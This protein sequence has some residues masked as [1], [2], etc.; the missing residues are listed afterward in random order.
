[1]DASFA[2]AD[3]LSLRTQFHRECD[4]L[5]Q[6]DH[7]MAWDAIW[8]SAQRAAAA[9]L[10]NDPTEEGRFATMRSLEN[11][12]AAYR[13][14]ICDPVQMLMAS[15]PLQS[16]VGAHWD[17]L[18]LALDEAADEGSAASATTPGLSAEWNLVVLHGDWFEGWDTTTATEV[19]PPRWHWRPSCN[20]YATPHD[21]MH[22]EAMETGCS[23]S[24]WLLAMA[25]TCETDRCLNPDPP[26]N[27]PISVR[28]WKDYRAAVWTGGWW[29]M[30]RVAVE[31]CGYPTPPT[32]SSESLSRWRQ[33]IRAA[34]HR[35]RECL[36]P[37]TDAAHPM[38]R[39]VVR[40]LND[41]CGIDDSYVHIRWP[42]AFVAVMADCFA[43]AVREEIDPV[44]GLGAWNVEAVTRSN[45]RSSMHPLQSY[46]LWSMAG[47]IADASPP[48]VECLTRGWTQT[49][50]D[51]LTATDGILTPDLL[52]YWRARLGSAVH[53]KTARR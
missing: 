49:E 31:C 48:S 13:R 37:V 22:P 45:E 35:L 32:T 44:V 6:S 29:D 47:I 7:A 1:M 43:E 39:P 38:R 53:T 23:M 30:E 36:G 27:V 10:Q 12:A 41:M 50:C 24:R 51:V 25:A 42:P 20:L 4:A 16:R 14:H 28:E 15:V 8:V 9:Q 52:R 46:S 34:E 33:P 11:L 5:V 40:W 3:L 18:V 2:P 26:T 21:F 17:R 19:D